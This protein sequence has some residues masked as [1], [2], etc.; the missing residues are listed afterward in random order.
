MQWFSLHFF[1]SCCLKEGV[2]LRYSQHVFTSS[3][4]DTKRIVWHWSYQSRVSSRKIYHQWLHVS[5]IATKVVTFLTPAPYEVVDLHSLLGFCTIFQ[6]RYE[7]NHLMDQNW[8][9][10]NKFDII[11]NWPVWKATHLVVQ[12]ANKWLYHVWVYVKDTQDLNS[13]FS[14]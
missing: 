8:G 12:D 3:K 2:S 9:L 5:V 1:A 11:R 7:G 13:S 4:L 6:K 10:G 14:Y